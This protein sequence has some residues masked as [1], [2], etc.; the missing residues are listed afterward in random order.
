MLIDIIIQLLFVYNHYLLF[1][2]GII[3]EYNIIKSFIQFNIK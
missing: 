2:S 3:N 1:K